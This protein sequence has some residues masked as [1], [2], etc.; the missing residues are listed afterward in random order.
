MK[1]PRK[2]F[3][4]VE[5]LVVAGLM[6]LMFGLIVAN[7]R[8][9][10]S[11]IR[12]AQDFA[13]ALLAAQS[14][15]LGRPEGAAVIIEADG[16]AYHE[17]DMPSP[18]SVAAPG[19]TF[20]APDGYKFRF[21]KKV[22]D[23]FITISPW[24]GLQGGTPV[25]RSLAG[26]TAENTILTPVGDDIEALVLRSPR[27]GAT[28]LKVGRGI[29]MVLSQSGVGDNLGAAH[30]YGRFST[31][32]RFAIV[33]DQTGRVTE[34]I[35]NLEAAGAQEPMSPNQIIYFL[36]S[37]IDDIDPNEPTKPLSS[38]R[39]AWVAVNPQTGRIHTAANEPTGVLETAREKARKGIAFGK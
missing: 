11:S 4:I 20:S 27:S 26:Q 36:F 7:G 38:E 5:L 39:S 3:T 29:T 30:G 24:L 32:G 9:R 35:R 31:L 25:R 21:R 16:A 10:P 17:A 33:F 8:P 15:A 28:P 12:A 6:A 2:A 22:G 23:G 1:S 18:I 14:R 37:E 19:G 34:V 13:S